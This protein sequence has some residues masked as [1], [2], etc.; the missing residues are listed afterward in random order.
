M[1][2]KMKGMTKALL[3]I[4]LA[5]G[6]SLV[7]GATS[8]ANLN[9]SATVTS[10]C[11]ISTTAVAFGSYDPVSGGDVS[12][13]GTVVVACTKNA[14]SLSVGLGNG[15]YYASGSRNMQGASHS[16]KLA[17]GLSQPVT[18]TPGAACPAIGAGTVTL[19]VS[20]YNCS[21]L[22]TAA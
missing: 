6:T 11:T 12:G 10:N 15:S 19:C 8:T 22:A 5:T 9:V 13:A 14:P 21:V 3:G 16:D 4:A 18:D 17:Y 1:N 7:F 2:T 20:L